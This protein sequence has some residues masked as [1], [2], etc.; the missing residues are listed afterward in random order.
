VFL[1]HCEPTG[2]RE[3]RPD[4]GLR[5]AIQP[6]AAETALPLRLA[7]MLAVIGGIAVMLLAPRPQAL[8][9]VA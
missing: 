7:G 8:G 6:D 5:E 4:D 1:H 9:E 3:A 2:P